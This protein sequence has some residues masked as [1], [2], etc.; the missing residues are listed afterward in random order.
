MY[1]DRLE[2]DKLQKGH[3]LN[4]TFLK[5]LVHHSAAAVFDYDNFTVETL[6]VWQG[7]D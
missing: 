6:D 1:D 3:I 4:D 2:A 5:F 7:L